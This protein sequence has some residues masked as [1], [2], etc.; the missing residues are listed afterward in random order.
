MAKS[1]AE[2]Q[3]AYRQRRDSERITEA[4]LRLFL[5][6]AYFLGRSDERHDREDYE[7]EW[8]QRLYARV[9]EDAACTAL[10]SERHVNDCIRRHGR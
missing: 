4:D 6:H 1:N 10:D 9:C 5:M 2:R 3:A 8:L 7:G